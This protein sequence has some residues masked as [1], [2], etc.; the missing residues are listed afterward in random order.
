MGLGNVGGTGSLR[1]L[2]PNAPCCSAS[3]WIPQQPWG[4]FL[5]V[6]VDSLASLWIPQNLWGEFLTL[7]GSVHVLMTKAPQGKAYPDRGGLFVRA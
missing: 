6:T 7:Q 4:G 1:L 5:S 2:P 3:L